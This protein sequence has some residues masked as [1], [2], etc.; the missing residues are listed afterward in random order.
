MRFD[1]VAGTGGIGKGEIFRLIG[2]NTLGR[3]ESRSAVLTDYR[4]YCKGHII[5][6]YPAR[7]SEGIFPVY[8][9]GRVGRD[10]RGNELIREMKT[11]GVNTE[12]VKYTDDPT[13]YSVCFLYENGEGGNI[14]T[15]N[16]ACSRVTGKEL[17]ETL[18]ILIRR[19]GGKGIVLGAPEVPLSSRL[20]YLREAKNAGCFTVC[21][22]LAE[23]ADMFMNSK[24][25]A[26]SDLISVNT[27]EAKAL[28]GTG[29]YDVLR[30]Q[31]PKIQLIVTQGK[32]GFDVYEGK[33]KK[34]FDAF[35]AVAVSTAGA[36][37]A[38]LGG[39][40]SGLAF[41]LP[42]VSDS[43]PCAASLGNICASFAVESPHTIPEKFSLYDVRKRAENNRLCI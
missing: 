25:G 21:S 32:S 1:W 10:E 9:C 29:G 23:E 42:L 3:E 19:H 24:G 5:L 17:T 16:D 15:C 28:G 6:S 11:E 36:G 13:K 2:N 26:V 31:N 12:F 4:D 37:D 20:E 8:V 14:T 34:H 30:E 33:N 41:G 22:V 40:I 18:N 43:G 35:P 27:E 7:L 39:V 38:L